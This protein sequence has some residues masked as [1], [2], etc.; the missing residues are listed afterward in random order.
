[1]TR[2]HRARQSRR[3]EVRPAHLQHARR[4]TEQRA[5]AGEVA[6][7]F[8]RQ[9]VTARGCA[10][11]TGQL[12]GLGGRQ[13]RVLVVE[14]LQDREPFF[15]PGDPVAPV[16]RFLRHGDNPKNERYVRMIVR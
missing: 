8:K 6:Q 4:Q 5:F 9:Q 15:Q 11:K 7:V 1:M 14:C 3:I 16:Q 12:G 2:L 13:P 10:G